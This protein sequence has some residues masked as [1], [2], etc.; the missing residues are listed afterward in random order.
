L[1]FL[2]KVSAFTV[3]IIFILEYVCPNCKQFNPSKKS[4]KA[5]IEPLQEKVNESIAEEEMDEVLEKMKAEH[6]SDEQSD[7][8]IGSRVRQRHSIDGQDEE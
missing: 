6:A 2:F 8:T 1:V 5:V 4:Q 3:Y 7:D